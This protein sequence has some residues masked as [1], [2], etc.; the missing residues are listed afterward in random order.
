MSC[1]GYYEYLCPTGHKFHRDFYEDDD[2]ACPTCGQLA[3]YRHQVDVTNGYDESIP[4]C[5]DA[6][7]RK[8]G[9]EKVTVDRNLYA[10][11]SKEWK[12]IRR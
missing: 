8:I 6:P 12:R 2:D 5:C 11:N 10:P 3:A 4:Y 1:E 9:S 7:V